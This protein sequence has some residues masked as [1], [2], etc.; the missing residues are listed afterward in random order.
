MY[1][2]IRAC[3]ENNYEAMS[4]EPGAWGEEWGREDTQDGQ[5][6]GN[7]S[8]QLINNS[9]ELEIRVTEEWQGK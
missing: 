4:Q 8:T 5:I 2:K 3:F 6:L 7:F 1:Q 9:N